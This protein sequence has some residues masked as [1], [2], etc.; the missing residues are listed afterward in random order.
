MRV[1]ALQMD[2]GV[3]MPQRT[4][5]LGSFTGFCTDNLRGFHRDPQLPARSSWSSH[6]DRHMGGGMGRREGEP[7]SQRFWRALKLT[8][9]VE[10]TPLSPNGFHCDP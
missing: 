9:L 2:L 4:Q 5:F 6:L 1:R 10:V 8:G 7:F 3:T